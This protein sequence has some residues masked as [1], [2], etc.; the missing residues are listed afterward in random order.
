MSF[1]FEHQIGADSAM[2]EFAKMCILLSLNEYPNDYSKEA[3]FIRDKFKEKYKNFWTCMIYEPGKG[4]IS[5]FYRD[6]FIRVTYGN[7]TFVILQNY[8]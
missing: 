7:K 5:S 6:F 3:E 4:Y 1:N 2:I 8:Y